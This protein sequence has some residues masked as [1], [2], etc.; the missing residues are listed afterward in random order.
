MLYWLRN[1][2]W[3]SIV[4]R[5]FLRRRAVDQAKHVLRECR[6]PSSDDSGVDDYLSHLVETDSQPV[7]V[8]L[9][10]AQWHTAIELTRRQSIQRS[11]QINEAWDE[12]LK[13]HRKSGVGMAGPAP[14]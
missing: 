8:R 12:A 6:F 3:G 7:T 14:A 11:L 10:A 1:V 13:A 2:I 5:L 9:R 4:L